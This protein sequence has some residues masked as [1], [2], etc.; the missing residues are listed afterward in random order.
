VPD[1]LPR[2]AAGETNATVDPV[3]GRVATFAVGPRPILFDPADPPPERRD[4]VD[5][6]G[7]WIHAGNPVLFPQAGTLVDHRFVEAGTTIKSHGLVYQRPWTVDI[8]EP[9]RLMLSIESD[10]QTQRAFPFTWRLEEEVEVLPSVLRC[11]LR[12]SN[13]GEVTLPAAPG[14]H[15][16]FALP[17]EEKSRLQLDAVPGY[18]APA[19][20]Q[21]ALDDVLPLSRR[22]LHVTWPSGALRL[23]TSEQFGCLVVYTAPGQPL[24]CIEPWVAPPNSLNDPTAR[25]SVRPG[26]TVTLWMEIAVLE[27]CSRT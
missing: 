24:V 3:G 22:P 17:L 20:P 12:I 10:A 8:Q 7:T 13:T 26:T 18:R 4:W 5:P 14:W 27:R 11:T 15:P 19:G 6:P 16:Y 1:T 9:S 21:G 23:T 25:L 2:I